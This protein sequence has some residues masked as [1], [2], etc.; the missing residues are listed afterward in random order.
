MPVYIRFLSFLLITIFV[1]Y[2]TNGF[3]QNESDLSKEELAKINRELDNP[4]AKYWSLVFKKIIL[5][6]KVLQ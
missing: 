6:I 5:L 2:S 3:A 4:L 1:T